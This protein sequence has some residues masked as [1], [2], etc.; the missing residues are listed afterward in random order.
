VGGLGA[1]L[2]PYQID[3]EHPLTGETIE[4]IRLIAAVSRLRD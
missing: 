2:E 1:Q 3:V 4:R